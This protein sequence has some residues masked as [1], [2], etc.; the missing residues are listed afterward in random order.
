VI[1]RERVEIGAVGRQP[2]DERAGALVDLGDGGD[3]RAGRGT[4]APMP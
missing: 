3:R 4:A 1:A 2:G